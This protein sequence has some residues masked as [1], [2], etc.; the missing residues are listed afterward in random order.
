MTDRDSQITDI[1]GG[2][3]EPT[4]TPVQDSTYRRRTN[5]QR[6][7]DEGFDLAET[8]AR[9]ALAELELSFDDARSV[10]VR[11]PDDVK[12]VGRTLRGWLETLADERGSRG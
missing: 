7:M 11:I 1:T 5:A 4:F 2:F 3:T 10:G 12:A 9:Q 6:R 8:H